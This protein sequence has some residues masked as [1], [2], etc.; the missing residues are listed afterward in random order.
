M[1]TPVSEETAHAWATQSPE[2]KSELLEML[3]TRFAG[4]TMAPQVLGEIKEA[5]ASLAHK[6]FKGPQATSVIDNVRFDTNE[7]GTL[8][9]S[10]GAL[11]SS[12]T[13]TDPKARHGHIVV[14]VEK[15][16]ARFL[17][18]P[19]VQRRYSIA[20][21]EIGLL[22]DTVF[23]SEEPIQESA[24]I[25]QALGM[26][27]SLPDTAHPDVSSDEWTAEQTARLERGL[28]D[29]DNLYALANA[30]DGAV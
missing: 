7:Q 21:G 29:Y 19:D 27:V 3:T 18:E 10:F 17:L 4:R 24:V 26:G 25:L 23:P 16:K 2:F 8:E 13:V 5:T 6:H 30:D 9:I 22:R 28:R 11:S 12:A 15:L 20:M 14:T 1:T